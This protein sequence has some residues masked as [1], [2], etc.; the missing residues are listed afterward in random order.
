MALLA[1]LTANLCIFDYGKSFYMQLT[2]VR[3]DP[4]G[5]RFYPA[6]SKQNDAGDTRTVVFFGSSR[7]KA[8]TAPSGLPDFKFVNRGVN[9]QTSAQINARFDDHV[10]PLRPDILILQ[11][12]GNDFK[13]IPLF[14]HRKEAIV[15]DCK[16][17]LAAIVSKSL[18]IG[19]TVIL[20]THFPIGEVPLIR[21]PFWSDDIVQ[22]GKEVNAFLHSLEGER[23][24][25]FDTVPV[26]A[27][28]NGLLKKAYQRDFI[29]LNE[30]GYDALNAELVPLLTSLKQAVIPAK[31]GIHRSFLWQIRRKS[32]KGLRGKLMAAE[33]RG[34][35]RRLG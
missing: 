24:I 20:T 12:G 2:A 29:H 11:A 15:A 14:P 25:H 5:L 8:W 26:L 19:A 18:D 21:R 31:A 22:A 7:A 34:G 23:V 33:G 16:S 6:D 10:R 35:P 30:A 28:E 4:L 27:D 32:E 3:L 1:S 17:N 13:G 9:G